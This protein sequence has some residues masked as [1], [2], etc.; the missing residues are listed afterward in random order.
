M[1]AAAETVSRG[2][3]ATLIH[4]GLPVGGCCLHVGCVPSKYW[5][6]AAEQ[7]HA[8]QASR[9]PGLHPQGVKVDQTAL[10][11]DLHE[12]ITA[13]RER[14]Y[15]PMLDGLEGLE[16]IH[17]WGRLVDGTTVE[18]NGR[19]VSGDAVLLATGSRTDLSPAAHLPEERVLSN[20]N[21]FAQE[22]LP[23]SVIVVGG[24]YIAVELSQ[25]MN[26]FGVKVTTLQRSAHVLS[27]QPAEIGGLLGEV[28]RDEGVNLVCGVDLQQ[29]REGGDG[30]DAVALVNG[31]EQIFTAQKVMMARGRQGNTQSLGL[32]AAGIE[33]GRNGFL[34]VNGRF[35]TSCATVYAVGD[36]LGGHMLVY[37]ASKEAERMVGGLFGDSVEPI[38]PDR[39]PWVVF[40]DPQVGGVGWSR[41]EAETLG[42]Q[43]EEA[44]LPVNRWPRF[45]TIHHERGFLKLFRDPSTD[46]LLGARAVC[47]EAGD[48]MSEL[49]LIREMKVPLST[50]A[51]R[52][53]PYLTLNEGVQRCA[54]NFFP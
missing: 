33:A 25:M 4:E 2:G 29:L 22:R 24:G 35:Q 10:F 51:D 21:L 46:L 34:E 26:R 38:P 50:I 47:P 9:F 52:V 31:Q 49:A 20:E 17:G 15:E 41:E 42:F 18:V 5:I 13:L 1:T 36:V 43:V 19:N 23:E 30:V 44:V 14:N 28:F 39:V 45:S 12:T 53:V 6:R 27:S 54:E 37:T 8:G 32:E 16:V 48:L 40:S 11:S 7:V 3:R